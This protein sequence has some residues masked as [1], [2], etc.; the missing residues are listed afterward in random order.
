MEGFDQAD[1]KTLVAMMLAISNHCLTPGEE[2]DPFR[3][4]DVEEQA[5]NIGFRLHELGGVGEMERA[6]VALAHALQSG[7]RS[8]ASAFAWKWVGIGDWIGP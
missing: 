7:H 6:Y 2:R 1:F 3:D 8:D 5:I 4:R